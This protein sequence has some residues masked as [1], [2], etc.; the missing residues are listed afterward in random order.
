MHCLPFSDLSIYCG[1]EKVRDTYKA[2]PPS[3]S[4]A[5]RCMLAFSQCLIQAPTVRDLQTWSVS[6]V[7]KWS[8]PVWAL[9][10]ASLFPVTRTGP[11]R[12][13][14][15]RCGK[16]CFGRWSGS[17]TAWGLALFPPSVGKHRFLAELDSEMPAASAGKKKGGRS[18]PLDLQPNF[19]LEQLL[20][21]RA[22]R[23]SS[24]TRPIRT[25]RAPRVMERNWRQRQWRRHGA[26]PLRIWNLPG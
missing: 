25:A 26:L 13:K 12:G 21:F 17:T 9:P 24:L 19:K 14:S 7:D 18:P 20:I 3:F 22:S 16:R 1:L 5:M 23:R 6:P 10:S 4:A 2:A 15:A 11:Y 8:T